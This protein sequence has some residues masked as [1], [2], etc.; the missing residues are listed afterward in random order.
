MSRLVRGGGDD[1]GD[2]YDE[3]EAKRN[4]PEGTGEG[5]LRLAWLPMLELLA[6]YE[7]PPYLLV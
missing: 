3:F 6:L 2:R 5:E 7:R 1:M 4:V